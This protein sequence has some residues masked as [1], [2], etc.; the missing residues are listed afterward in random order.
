MMVE[1]ATWLAV[2]AG[3][4]LLVAG[5]GRR[6]RTR[7]GSAAAGTVYDLLQEDKRNALEVI[8]E[9]RAAARDPEHADDE[10]PEAPRLR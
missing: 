5:I 6:A 8:V 3:V 4:V 1:A 10:P 9:D 7:T 2:L